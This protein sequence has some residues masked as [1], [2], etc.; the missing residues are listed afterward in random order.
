MSLD[1]VIVDYGMGNLRS[2]Q[3]A[4]ESIGHIALISSDPKDLGAAQALILPGV[5]AFGDGMKNIFERGLYEPILAHLK[6]DN[7]LMGICLG[8]QLLFETGY[9]DGEQKGLGW[10]GG[11]VVRFS[12][13][14][15]MKIPHMG[16]NQIRYENSET[17]FESVSD[18]SYFYFVH[19]YHVRPTD[20][21]VVA[22]QTDHGIPFVSSVRKGKLLATQFHPEKSQKPGVELL[23]YFVEGIAGL[24]KTAGENSVK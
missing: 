21:E 15:G 10:L 20:L 24:K 8:M 7:P 1:L 4:L 17:R 6:A 5:G 18:Q 14:P 12:P 13:M 11:E 23:R 2:V 19:A 22:T 9:E 3:K 16:W